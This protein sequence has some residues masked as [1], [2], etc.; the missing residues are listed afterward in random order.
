M[1]CIYPASLIYLSLTI[2]LYG[3][4]YICIYHSFYS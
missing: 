3:N 4:V 2:V 1:P